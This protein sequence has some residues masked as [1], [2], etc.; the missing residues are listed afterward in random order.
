MGDNPLASGWFYHPAQA[1]AEEHVGPLS[2][3]RLAMLGN[4]GAL[5]PTDGVWHPTLPGWIPAG[6]IPGLFAAPVAGPWSRGAAL[7]QTAAPTGVSGGETAS[8]AASGTGGSRSHLVWIIPL[9]AFLVIALGLG[10]FFGLRSGDDARELS[11]STTTETA[12]ASTTGSTEAPTSTETPSTLSTVAGE[13]G[14]WLVMMYEDA[15]DEILEED[16]C[17]DMNEAELVGSTDQ[18][19]IVAQMDRYAGGYAGDGDVTSTKRYL[20]TQ[21]GDLYT[22]NSQELA[23]LGEAGHGRRPDSVRF[24]HLGDT[25]VSGRAL[26]ADPVQPRRW[27]DGRLE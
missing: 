7:S 1:P 3:E 2:W 15:D 25:D 23:D 24:R 27:L 21:D 12:T 18:V 17:F 13:P 4:T 11:A 14:T 9:A 22:V 10:L 5:S 20:V 19:T 8:P 6:E 26:R 16:I